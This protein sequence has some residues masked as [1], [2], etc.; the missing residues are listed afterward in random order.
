MCRRNIG[1]LRTCPSEGAEE[2]RESEREAGLKQSPSPATELC[3][4][5]SI[6]GSYNTHNLH[7]TRDLH[8]SAHNCV[9]L[10]LQLSTAAFFS[11]S[12]ALATDEHNAGSHAMLAMHVIPGAPSRYHM[13]RR[14]KHKCTRN[15]CGWADKIVAIKPEYCPSIRV[16]WMPS[17][18]VRVE[19]SL[20]KM[21]FP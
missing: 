11:F 21:A 3:G 7:K 5:I 13:R 18:C 15:D 12:P 2:E 8:I 4:F 10:F 20:G 19:M 9:D 1:A 14:A 17:A 16:E 6:W